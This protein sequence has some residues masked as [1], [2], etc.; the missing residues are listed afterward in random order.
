VPEG[1]EFPVQTLAEPEPMARALHTRIAARG[2]R[3]ILFRSRCA[4]GVRLGFVITAAHR[5]ADLDRGVDTLAAARRDLH[6]GR[7]DAGLFAK[8]MSPC[9]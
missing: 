9:G 6:G 4:G 5:L 7:T 3:A 8:E 1:G 2:V